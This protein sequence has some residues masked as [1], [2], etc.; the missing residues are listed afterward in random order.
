MIAGLATVWNRRST[1][2][3]ARL[4]DRGDR[5]APDGAVVGELVLGRAHDPAVLGIAVEGVDH[6]RQRRDPLVADTLA[7]HAELAGITEADRTG[8]QTSGGV[9]EVDLDAGRA[10]QLAGVA[11]PRA[12]CHPGDVGDGEE[13]RRCA[14]QPR[15]R[16]ADPDG[17]RHLGVGDGGEQLLH[18]FVAD[19]GAPAVHLD[20]Q[21]LGVGGD[22]IV[23]G[24]LDG[25]D[26]DA[27]EQSADEQHVDPAELGVSVGLAAVA[28]TGTRRGGEHAERGGGDQQADR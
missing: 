14:V 21:R 3:R 23:D 10:E 28:V 7:Q 12:G 8:P 26:D 6:A 2:G 19:D 15:P 27:V 1:N 24:V 20:D 16:R 11:D 5:R 17:D 13:L 18:A 4:A 9:T 22:G 25:V